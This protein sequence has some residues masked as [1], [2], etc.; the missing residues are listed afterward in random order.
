[1]TTTPDDVLRF[2]FDEAGEKRW[3]SANP[4]FDDTV[5]RRFAAVH[6]AGADG[7]FDDWAA[8]PRG[9]LA[10]VILLDQVPRNM[11]RGTAAAYETDA[12]A[13]NV[14]RAAMDRGWALSLSET[15]RHF[16]LMPFMHSEDLADQDL[17][18]TFGETLFEDDDF[19]KHA[20]R[21]RE[22]IV[23]YG[24]FPHR[25]AILGRTTTPDEQT[26]LDAGGGWA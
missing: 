4:D 5:R 13:L 21:H 19:L 24:R 2:W 25:N 8:G 16:L 15:E 14:A 17:A 1:M 12:R 10:L 6:Q 7:A 22:V 11:Y 9:A 20:R 23:R 18:V 26:Y 3:W